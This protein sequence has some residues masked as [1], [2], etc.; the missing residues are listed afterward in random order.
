[1]HGGAGKKAWWGSGMV[2][3]GCGLVPGGPTFS[4][5]FARL[6]SSDVEETFFRSETQSVLHAPLDPSLAGRTEGEEQG[7]WVSL[8]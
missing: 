7:V 8:W 3:D 2:P 4:A 5:G 1:M 6:V